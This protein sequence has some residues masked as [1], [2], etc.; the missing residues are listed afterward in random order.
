MKS[1]LI[2]NLYFF[3][4]RFII[5][6]TPLLL[7]F[8]SCSPTRQ[9]PEGSYY[10]KENKVI[11]D[12]KEVSDYDIW[13]MAKPTTNRKFFDLFKIK[14]RVYS[15][16]D[17]GKENKFKGFFKKNFGEAAVILDTNYSVYSAT[18]MK[19]Y[20]NNKGFFKSIVVP[21]VVYKGKKTAKVNFHITAND[22]YLMNSKSYEIK[23]SVIREII[24][25][26]TNNTLLKQNMRFDTDVFSSERDRI[27]ALLRNNGYYNFPREYIAYD[28]DTNY[29]NNTYSLTLNVLDLNINDSITIS[30]PRYSI[31]K[32]SIFTD[33]DPMT[34]PLYS[35]HFDYF[36]NDY[37][38]TTQYKFDFN[39]V[40]KL[41]YRPSVI[42]RNINIHSDEYYSLRRTNNTFLRLNDLKNFGYININY[43]ELEDADTPTLDCEISLNP[44][45][46]S[47][48]AYELKVTNS[49]GNPGSGIDFLYFNRNIFR[50]AQLLTVRV[51]T[52]FEA[53]R[54]IGEQEDV[55]NRLWFFNTLELNGSVGLEIP[56]F[57]FPVRTFLGKQ[58]LRPKT[59]ITVGGNYQQRPDYTRTV[60]NISLGYEWRQ[61]K[62][63]RHLF[64]PI[65][66]N[67]VKI[68]PDSSFLAVLSQY[69]R[70]I[71]EQ[72]SDHLVFA[73][74]YSFVFSN[75]VSEEQNKYS[76]FRIN[77]ESVGNIL[78]LY[79]TI[80][81]SEKNDFDQYLL[82]KIPYANYLLTDIDYRKYI[83]ITD[84][85]LFAFRTAFGVG[86]P[87][88]N[89]WSIP[90]EKSFFLGGANSLR[91]WRMR[92]IGP[93][94]YKSDNNFERSGD[95]KLELSS[96]IRFPIWSYFNGA[97]FADA[98]NVWLMRENPTVPNGHIEANRFY[99]EIAFDA[100]MGL[101]LDFSFFIVR[102]DAAVALHH[103][104]YDLGERWKVKEMTFRDVLVNFAI[105]Y[106]F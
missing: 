95:L 13:T 74:K 64:S 26:D 47:E 39:Y 6:L 15:L 81:K 102:F 40:E 93:G 63:I 70:R 80:A 82:F 10:L 59:I 22:A 92:T 79:N 68:Y 30:H 2:R 89:S 85:S 43:K 8:S 27:V 29:Q 20:M 1:R 35:N 58:T 101:R 11:V 32:V 90:F 83:K 61:S 31:G 24:L 36:W 91:G 48:F 94:S 34:R 4:L 60:G 62:E 96:E 5:L 25:N 28:I 72:Y 77:L 51:G 3:N 87:L 103:P 67:T 56:N 23:D 88:L 16:F 84:K 65:D 12:T 73:T 57:V 106:P 46:R 69:N 41:K 44:M 104:G 21:E 66:I 42:V 37:G 38:D 7:F 49:G 50:R 78:N 45:K 17:H 86:I 52:A 71:R 33:Y 76:F 18:Q 9:V 100:G 105:G 98:G 97:I 99:K 54:I 14:V 53:Q 19:M 75:Q 55:K